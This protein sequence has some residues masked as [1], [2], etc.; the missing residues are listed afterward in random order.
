MYTKTLL[1]LALTATSIFASS[2]ATDAKKAGLKP[3]PSSATELLKLIDNPKNPIT[4][5]KIELGKKLYFEPRISKSG[6][7]SCNSCHNLADGGDDGL[8]AAVG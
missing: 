7:I 5:K 1:I 6:L 8:S 2:L 3:I 4:P